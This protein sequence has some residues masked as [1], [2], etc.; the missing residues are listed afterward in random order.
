MST[1]M[2]T[3]QELINKRAEA[4]LDAEIDRMVKFVRDSR[5]LDFSRMGT[6][7]DMP[8]LRIANESGAGYQTQSIR[9]IIGVHS[10]DYCKRLHSVWLPVYIKEETE[11]FL[12]E[13]TELQERVAE[14][15]QQADNLEDSKANRS[16]LP[17]Y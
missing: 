13:F 14:I 7:K 4:K 9:S 15:G 1:E 8:M 5:I 16:D 17:L 10:S 2:N 12:K 11:L 3:L 6:P